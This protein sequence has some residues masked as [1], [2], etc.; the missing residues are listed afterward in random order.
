M[1]LIKA[2]M[3]IGNANLRRSVVHLVEEVAGEGALIQ[4]GRGRISFSNW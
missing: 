4:V 1:K 3:Q 2:F